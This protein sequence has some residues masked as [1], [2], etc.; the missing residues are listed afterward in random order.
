MIFTGTLQPLG[1]IV[2]IAKGYHWTPLIFNNKADFTSGAYILSPLEE[3]S[4][5]PTQNAGFTIAWLNANQT[6]RVT[7][8]SLRNSLDPAPS[9]LPSPVQTTFSPRQIPPRT[10][11]SFFRNNSNGAASPSSSPPANRS[12]SNKRAPILSRILS[13]ATP[14]AGS[15]TTYAA[16]KALPVD[17]ARVRRGSSTGYAEPADDLTGAS[18][19][20]EAVDIMVDAIRRACEDIGNIH[21]DI[22]SDGDVVRSVLIAMF[23]EHLFC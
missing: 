2:A 1:D 15:Q 21:G 14:E 18:S 4:R 11:S 3:A 5:D 20:K 19:C 13:N 6:T 16:F 17:P 12:P 22:I 8:Y 23:S 9:P 10:N 7:S